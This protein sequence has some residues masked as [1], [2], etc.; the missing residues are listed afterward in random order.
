M[1]LMESSARTRITTPVATV[2]GAERL[3]GLGFRYWLTGFRTGDISCWERAW[4][5]YSNSLGTSGA[6]GAITDLSC[7]VRAI[8][9]HARRDLETAAVDCDSFCRD[10]CVAIAMIAACQ[11]NACP[12]MRACAFSLLGCAM[13][14]EVVQGAEAFAATMRGAEQVLRPSYAPAATMSALPTPTPVLQ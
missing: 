12:A 4:S 13:I 9:R 8:S 14:D 5:A 1:K 7:W 3:V 2:S 10:E 11:H 6:K